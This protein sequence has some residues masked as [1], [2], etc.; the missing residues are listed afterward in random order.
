MFT[1]P[2]FLLEGGVWARDYLFIACS[3]LPPLFLFWLCH[4]YNV[5]QVYIRTR[6]LTIKSLKFVV[7]YS[8]C[9]PGRQVKEAKPST[10]YLL[11]FQADFQIQTKCLAICAG[12]ALVWPVSGVILH[13]F[14]VFIV[15]HKVAWFSP[16]IFWGSV[17][18]TLQTV[19]TMKIV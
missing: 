14:I 12:P 10:P 13:V 2:L 16:P 9:G 1:R 15:V 6:L 11:Y 3:S 19:S 17:S 18:D 4:F 5:Q 8:S 7:Q